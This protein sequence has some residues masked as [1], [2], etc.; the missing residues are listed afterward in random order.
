MNPSE[1]IKPGSLV[2]EWKDYYEQKEILGGGGYGR[3]YLV[4]NKAT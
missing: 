2:K 4:K 3:V 1:T